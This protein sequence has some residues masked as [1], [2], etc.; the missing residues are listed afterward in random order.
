MQEN[1]DQR[2]GDIAVILPAAG[3]S[4]RL[5][6]EVR[7]PYRKIAGEPII[8][9]TLRKFSQAPGVGEIILAVHPDDIEWVRDRD[10]ESFSAAGA[11]LAVVGGS[12][13]AESVWNAIQTVSARASYIAVHDAVR[14]FVS[15]DL[16]AA[17]FATARRRRAAVPVVPMVD[18]T[19][20]VEGDQVILTLPRLGMMRVQTPQVFQSDLLIEA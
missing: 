2:D 13:R 19:K 9:R 18:T 5:L 15:P 12:N 14:P 8:F 6:G 1:Q 11:T 17:L 3:E 10:W 16:L 20:R 7:K 4:L